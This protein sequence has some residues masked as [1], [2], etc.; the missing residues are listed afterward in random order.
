MKAPGAP[1]NAPSGANHQ[2]RA[3]VAPPA[4]CCTYGAMK[5]KTQASPCWACWEDERRTNAVA[6]VDRGSRP[7]VR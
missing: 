4:P 2:T 7:V 1:T 5:G 6:T 3:G